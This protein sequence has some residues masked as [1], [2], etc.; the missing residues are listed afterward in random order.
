VGMPSFAE[1]RLLCALRKKDKKAFL[2]FTHNTTSI[3]FS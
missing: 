3:G 1:N 2:L